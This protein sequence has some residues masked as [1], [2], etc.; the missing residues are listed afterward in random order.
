MRTSQIYLSSITRSGVAAA[1]LA[2]LCMFTITTISSSNA[3]ATQRVS[4][5]ALVNGEPITSLDLEN[6]MKFL[7]TLSKLE[8][9][10][11]DFRADTLQKLVSEKIKIQA[12]EE[13]LG[14]VISEATNTARQLIDQNFK[15]GDKPGGQV[16]KERGI[17]VSTVTDKYLSDIV[18]GN[19]LR[20]RFPRQFENLD[21]LAEQELKK[22]EAAQSEPQI[23]LSEILLQPNPK[24]PKDK[25]NELADKI[26]EALNRKANFASIAS[27]YSEAATA[28]QGGRVNWMLLSRLPASLQTALQDAEE[29]EIIGPTELDGRIY[30][31]KKDGFRENGLADPKAATLTMARAI[32]PLAADASKEDRGK[33]GEKILRETADLQNCDEMAELNKKLGSE[34]LPILNDLQVGSLSPQLQKIIMPL[35]VGQKSPALPFSEGMTVFMVCKRVQPTAELPDIE[36]LKRVEFDKLFNSISGRYLLRLQRKAVIDYRS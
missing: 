18:W 36:T 1:M 10:E 30:I 9:D 14:S 20:V 17:S 19:V 35:Q 32:V 31:L 16:L 7:R 25:T 12:A 26:I 21:N 24:R 4:V 5:V 8:M 6:R 27:Q 34:A 28:Q 2:C 29:G 15:N 11:A 23:K 13:Q 3:D 22:L 33:A